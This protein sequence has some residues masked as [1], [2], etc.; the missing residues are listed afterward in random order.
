MSSNITRMAVCEKAATVIEKLAEH[1]DASL[2]SAETARDIHIA[3]DQMAWSANVAG[4]GQGYLDRLA[5][6]AKGLH[7]S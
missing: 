6:V 2:L 5:A 1:V 7:E 3:I 4:M